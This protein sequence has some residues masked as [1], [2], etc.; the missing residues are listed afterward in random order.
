MRVAAD[1]LPLQEN[2]VAIRPHGAAQ[3]LRIPVELIM[4]RRVATTVFAVMFFVLSVGAAAAATVTLTWD[5]SPEQDVAGYVVYYGMNSGQYTVSVDVGNQT[6]FQYTEANPLYRYY[7]A[8]RAYNVSGLQSEFSPEVS[9]ADPGAALTLT[10]LTSNVP[11]PQ[12]PGASITF[13]AVTSSPAQFKWVIFDGFEWKTSQYW[14]TNNSF[15]WNPTTL[16]ANYR[17]GVWARSA[18]STYDAADSDASA[19]YLSFPIVEPLALSSLGT[20]LP[21]PQKV[22]TSITLTAGA[23][24]GVAPYQYKWLISD[25]TSWTVAQQWS[26][27]STFTWTPSVA[28][29]NYSIGVWVRSATNTVDAPENSNAASTLAFTITS[30]GKIA[31]TSVTANKPAPQPVGSKIQFTASASGASAYQFK[32]WVFDGATWTIAQE[33]SS[34]NKFMWVPAAA[35]PNYQVLAR[36]RDAS[37]SSESD[38]V[39]IPFPVV[40]ASGK[41]NGRR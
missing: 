18:S 15:T 7:F 33:W 34:S 5:P 36:V 37:N 30:D 13:A 6:S 32:W 9:T 11:A 40:A 39:S 41:G 28:K 38:G 29:A 19:G 26:T 17:V 25:G 23:T 27:S 16:N 2:T 8:V 20:N 35:S 31:L 14:S 22:G 4:R 3:R 1:A 21:S 24:G 12:A 10:S